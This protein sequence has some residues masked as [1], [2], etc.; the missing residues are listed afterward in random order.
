MPRKALISFT[1]ILEVLKK[2][3]IFDENHKLKCRSDKVWKDACILMPDK[4]L[5]DTLN[6]YVRNNRWDL[7]INLK[8]HFNIPFEKVVIDSINIINESYVSEE[9]QPF[10]IAENVNNKLP[11]LYFDL[12]L[13]DEQ[14]KSTY[15]I[16]KLYKE[17]GNNGKTY[18]V[19]NTGWTD[20]ISEACFIKNKLPCAYTFKYSKIFDS[21]DAQ[22]YLRIYGFCKECGAEFRAHCLYEP[23][24]DTGIVLRVHTVDTSGIPHEKKRSIKGNTRAAI[25]QELLNKKSRQ[26]RNDAVK[27][28]SYG[29]SEPPYV[30]RQCTLRKIKEEAIVREL[31]INKNVDAINSLTE[32]K[33]RGQYAGYIKDIAK[34]NFYCFYWSPLQMDLYKSLIKKVRKI[35]IDATGK[36]M[37]AI[38]K[39]NGEK[40]H[41]FLYQIIIKGENSIQ[42]LFQMITEKHDT[43][44]ITYWLREILRYGAPIPPEVNCDY[45]MALLNATSLAFNERNLKNYISDCYRWISGENLQ[46]PL[47]CYIRV[48]IAH[49]IKIICNKNVFDK[50]HPKVKDFFV[51]CV[52]IMSTCDNIEDFI[53]LLISVFIVAY[54]EYDIDKNIEK[55]KY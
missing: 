32:L 48:N 50:K 8:K 41:I 52:G 21:P 43:N 55:Q 23:A 27:D 7:E 1:I 36:L 5:P 44:L 33:Y 20:V 31:G 38:D 12:I 40:K 19:L 34:D 4:L 45:S 10:D 14:W 17:K 11:K 2:F 46:Y 15:P 39:L 25:G 18:K 13:S 26:W 53:T 47:R 9:F 3:E 51:R 54:S 16:S 35:E 24:P 30:A 6:F 28:L 22:I 49:L 37:K 42:P 29:D